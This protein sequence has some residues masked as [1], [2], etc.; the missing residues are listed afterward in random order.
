MYGLYYFY[1][2]SN[3]DGEWGIGPTTQP[4]D[5]QPLRS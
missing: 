4:S 1:G 5:Y 2:H 3:Q